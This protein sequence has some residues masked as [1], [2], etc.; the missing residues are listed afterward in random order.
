MRR[1]GRAA[2]GNLERGVR[3]HR[4]TPALGAVHTGQGEGPRPLATATTLVRALLS[5]LVRKTGLAQT[6]GDMSAVTVRGE[7]NS[8]ACEVISFFGT[9]Q[10]ARRLGLPYSVCATVLIDLIFLLETKDRTID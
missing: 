10:C 4:R 5:G 3:R 2:V 9:P 7:R 8:S 6:V 1:C